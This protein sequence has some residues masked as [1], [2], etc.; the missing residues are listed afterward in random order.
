MSREETRFLLSD[1]VREFLAQ[2]RAVTHVRFLLPFLHTGMDVLDAGCGPGS[3]TVDLAEHVA[4]GQ[5]IGVDIEEYHVEMATDLAAKRDVTNA[6]FEIGDV[7]ALEFPDATFDAVLLH[8]VVEYLP[9]PVQI[10]REALRVLKPGGVLGTRHGDWGGFL[11]APHDDMIQHFLDLFVKLMEYGGGDAH[12]G[13]HQL[14]YLRQAGFE[15]IAVSASYD[16][17]TPR[18]AITA[19]TAQFLAGYCE[20]AEFRLAIEHA[21]LDVAESLPK[22]ARAIRD[23][24]RHPDAFA[25]EAWGEAVAWKP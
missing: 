12:C 3:I 10:Y 4:P 6:H 11:L 25:A 19:Q 16:C 21:G 18:P 8:G 23:W 2:R 14:S 20:S 13:R 17:W 7:S 5:V 9:N 24:G 15:H 22:Y 1:D